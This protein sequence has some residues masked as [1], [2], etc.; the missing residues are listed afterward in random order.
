MYKSYE[1]PL[2]IK[3]MKPVS[4]KRKKRKKKTATKLKW[5]LLSSS[6]TS[7]CRQGNMN[8]GKSFLF[9]TMTNS[10]AV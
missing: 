9:R 2:K 6:Y 7:I 8:K 3:I 10:F 5:I 4:K 1:P